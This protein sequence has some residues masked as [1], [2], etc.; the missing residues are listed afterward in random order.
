MKGLKFILSCMTALSLLVACDTS[1]GDQSSKTAASLLALSETQKEDQGAKLSA[2]LLNK[3]F[4]DK[5]LNANVFS[6]DLFKG[7]ISG[8]NFN[9][10][11]LLEDLLTKGRIL[12]HWEPGLSIYI[13][14][15]V[16]SWYGVKFE[17]IFDDY[18]AHDM[19]A[20]LETCSGTLVTTAGT[21]GGNF[22]LTLNGT[23][24]FKNTTISID[25][26]TVSFKDVRLGFDIINALITQSSVFI[27]DGNIE[28]DGRGITLDAVR[29]AAAALNAST[30]LL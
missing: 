24:T 19:L 30:E 8:S 28:I 3:V 4:S 20:P 9:L 11:A 10:E 15:N 22:I 13:S 23:V 29:L 6:N 1:S 18:W 16:V 12:I 25:P 26:V 21:S 27:W 7:I 17:F 14:P 2:V 5:T